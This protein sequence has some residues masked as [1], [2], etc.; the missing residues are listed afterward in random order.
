M[1]KWQF[2]KKQQGISLYEAPIN[3]VH[4]ELPR[5]REQKFFKIIKQQNPSIPDEHIYVLI[6][7]AYTSKREGVGDFSEI[8][9][10]SCQAY[11]KGEFFIK[12]SREKYCL[13]I[14]KG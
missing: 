7:L 13:C 8:L 9:L 2:V 11:I 12:K 14:R 5:V 6:R 4:D 1:V 3:E 10:D